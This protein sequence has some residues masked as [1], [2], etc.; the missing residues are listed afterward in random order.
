MDVGI[1]PFDE[2]VVG[3]ALTVLEEGEYFLELLL[4]GHIVEDAA[5]VPGLDD[6]LSDIIVGGGVP[7]D[8]S[9]V[10]EF[11]VDHGAEE[12]VLLFVDPL[13][14]FEFDLVQ[15]AMVF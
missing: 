12:F 10:V 8:I 11:V 7:F 15:N 13:F 6:V 1:A 9:F 4:V 5:F 3:F 2:E 14:F